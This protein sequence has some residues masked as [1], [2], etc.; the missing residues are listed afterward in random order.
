MSILWVIAV[1]AVKVA[2]AVAVAEGVGVV[3]AVLVIAVAVKIAV[4]LA[5]LVAVGVDELA[6]VAAGVP[7]GLDSVA[8]GEGGLDVLE[9]T[10]VTLGEAVGEAVAEVLQSA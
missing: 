6:A 5:V 3:V 7:F 9:G 8:V 2:V 10:A 1:E 4:L